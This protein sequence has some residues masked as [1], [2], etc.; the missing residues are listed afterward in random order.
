M[1]TEKSRR[2]GMKCTDNEQHSIE[3]KKKALPGMLLMDIKPQ[4]YMDE[5]KRQSSLWLP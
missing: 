2:S 5:K 1:L 4:E 3:T